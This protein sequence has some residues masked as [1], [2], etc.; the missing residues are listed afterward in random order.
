MSCTQEDNSDQ[1]NPIINFLNADLGQ[2][3]AKADGKSVW[4]KKGTSSE[5]DKA[6]A[7]AG[8]RHEDDFLSLINRSVQLSVEDLV[9]VKS[10][11]VLRK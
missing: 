5:E 11:G 7:S 6:E 2:T 10:T 8:T 4:K 1:I 9:P 3:G